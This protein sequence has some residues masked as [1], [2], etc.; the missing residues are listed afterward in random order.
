[1]A[2][3]RD[4]LF[5]IMRD[6]H[7]IKSFKKHSYYIVAK[8]GGHHVFNDWYDSNM[9]IWNSEQRKFVDLLESCCYYL[10]KFDL[11]KEITYFKELSNE[12]IEEFKKGENAQVFKIV[13]DIKEIRL[14][15]SASS[16][17][18]CLRELYDIVND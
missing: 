12:I 15:L 18:A 6:D 17:L 8:K 4:R 14:Y 9:D 10:D 3:L 5:F 7:Y 2:K 16:L 1:M 13:R 11:T